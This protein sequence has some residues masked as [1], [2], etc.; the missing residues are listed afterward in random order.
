MTIN[1]TMLILIILIALV[2]QYIVEA[3]K[4]LFKAVE[5]KWGLSWPQKIFFPAL[6]SMFWTILLCFA[7]GAGIFS[8]FGFTL[9]WAWLDYVVT[10]IVA[11]LG[12]GAVYDLVISVRE[13]KD[14]L[15]VESASKQQ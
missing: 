13:Y 7:A 8:A 10:G 3:L 14:K 11:S 12:A 2:V 15:A 9:M 4:G 6:N 1:M 5:K